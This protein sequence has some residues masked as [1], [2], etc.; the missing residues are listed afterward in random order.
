MDCTFEIYAPIGMAFYKRL[1]V[2]S[3]ILAL[4]LSR[5]DVLRAARQL[6]DIPAFPAPSSAQITIPPE[7]NLALVHPNFVYHT[8]IIRPGLATVHI[9][10]KPKL[11]ETVLPKSPANS[12]PLPTSP[13]LVKPLSPSDHVRSHPTLSN[14]TSSLLPS[15]QIPSLPTEPTMPSLPSDQI[16]FLPN[17]AADHK[18]KPVPPAATRLRTIPAN[19]SIPSKTPIIPHLLPPRHA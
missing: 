4:S 9:P 11:P 18:V 3:L 17:V 8:E 7:P 19:P 15:S 14:P 2:V 12:I 16:Q 5:A 1:F 10:S 13:T 6:L